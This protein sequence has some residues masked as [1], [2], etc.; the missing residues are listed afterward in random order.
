MVFSLD[1]IFMYWEQVGVFKTILPFLLIFAV[2]FG[3]ISYMNLFKKNK[4]VQ[5]IIAIVLGLLAIQ[6]DFFSDFLAAISPRLGV[7]IVILLV[8]LILTGL[9]IPE[10]SQGTVGWILM[11]VGVIIFLIVLGSSYKSLPFFGSGSFWGDDLIAWLVLV[12]LLI[13]VIVAVV[14]GSSNSKENKVAEKLASLF[15]GKD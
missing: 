10:K 6:A 15:E 8:L 5:V 2:V 7:G 13:G 11:G 9:F 3:I 14:V 12:G 1:E 4:G